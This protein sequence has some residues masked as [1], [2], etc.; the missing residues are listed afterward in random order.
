MSTF[1][2]IYATI[3]ATSTNEFKLSNY[4]TKAILY[5]LYISVYQFAA[6]SSVTAVA[7]RSFP[8][9]NFKTYAPKHLGALNDFGVGGDHLSW[10]IVGKRV[11]MNK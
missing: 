8:Y 7:D 5:F 3:L 4:L 9:A 1:L 6:T 11:D 10:C 2:E